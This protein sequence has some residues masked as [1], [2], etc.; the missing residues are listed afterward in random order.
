MSIGLYGGSFDPIHFGHLITT[1]AV[2]EKRNLDKII[3]MPSYIS[4][5]KQDSVIVEDCHRLEMVRLATSQFPQ[6]LVSDLEINKKTVSYTFD[7]LL[8]LKNKYSDIELI[9]G[10][11]NLLV[12]EKW[13]NPDKIF[14]MCKVIVMKRLADDLGT[15]RNKYFEKAI[16]AETPNIEISSTEIRNRVKNNLPIDFLVPARVSEYIYQNGLYK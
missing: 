14:Q 11:D 2:L 10:L 6:F 7:T 13:H 12:F 5:L 8:E 16:F 15:K 3:F 9:I 4:P 1:Q